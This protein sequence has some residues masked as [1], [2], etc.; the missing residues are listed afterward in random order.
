MV[1][2]E[3]EQRPVDFSQARSL[4]DVL[5]EVRRMGVRNEALP[6]SDGK[7]KFS[8][9]D[10]ATSL[11]K[12]ARL[13][14]QARR[15][16]REPLLDREVTPDQ[17]DELFANNGI[18]S[19]AGLRETLVRV[20]R[21]RSKLNED[22][23]KLLNE[24]RQEGEFNPVWKLSDDEFMHQYPRE[25]ATSEPGTEASDLDGQVSRRWELIDRAGKSKAQMERRQKV[26]DWEDARQR[27]VFSP[28]WITQPN[29]VDGYA[30]YGQAQE[31]NRVRREQKEEEARRR[32]FTRMEGVGNM[33]SIAND[34]AVMMD[35]GKAVFSY[36]G[37][38][39]AKGRDGRLEPKMTRTYSLPIE[40]APGHILTVTL[41][42]EAEVPV[43]APPR[44]VPEHFQGVMVESVDQLPAYADAKASTPEQRRVIELARAQMQQV[45]TKVRAKYGIDL[46]I[47]RKLAALLA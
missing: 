19:T 25:G 42:S 22:T 28:G 16:P 46:G 8:A 27:V 18:T 3:R 26:R 11:E 41:F 32:N 2:P 13:A 29:S 24:I 5:R 33:Y 14:V 21:G 31:A 17:L 10:L 45:E 9:T 4:E 36:D 15:D 12:A 37:L 7:V 43:G 35:G 40:G 39:Y 6:T 30:Q 44:E 1:D 47:D 34:I 23:F 20:M 38:N